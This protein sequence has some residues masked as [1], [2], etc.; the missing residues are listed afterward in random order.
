[1]TAGVAQ[2]RL[3]ALLAATTVAAGL[4]P[5][6]PGSA[7][8]ASTAAPVPPG[9][10]AV[11][12]MRFPSLVTALSAGP[13]PG[14]LALTLANG[15]ADVVEDGR[16]TAEIPARAA[17]DVAW[18]PGTSWIASASPPRR[19]TS[20]YFLTDAASGAWVALPACA[21]SG[22]QQESTQLGGLRALPGAVAWICPLPPLPAP[23]T[24]GP[25]GSWTA[26]AVE[27]LQIPAQ[28][29]VHPATA[30]RLAVHAVPPLPGA[31]FAVAPGVSSVAVASGGAVQVFTLPSG[32]AETGVLSLAPLTGTL[33]WLH[34][35]T[36][37]VADRSG[38]YLWNRGAPSQ[39]A[40]VR[41]QDARVRW[42]APMDG[43]H[44]ALVLDQLSVGAPPVYALE[45]VTASG[46]AQ[47]LLRGQLG[48][49]LGPSA[50]GT[51]LWREEGVAMGVYN[52]A[53]PQPGPGPFRLEAVPVP[54]A[55]APGPAA[56]GGA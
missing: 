15:T 49:V 43:G 29:P 54:A 20:Q 16:V 39:A 48:Y 17:S 24:G 51:R 41:L 53:D 26:W 23:I 22:G 33:A 14:D 44:A 30:T 2:R 45:R 38:L 55:G 36:L 12:A 9:V 40:V 34:G 47:V 13:R 10:R 19:G 7:W 35:P 31:A 42:I 25:T 28:G 4:A 46:G 50:G 3:R 18:V 32:T 21:G 11:E 6:T 56:R 5:A 52:R 1:M 27:V 8:A 37:A